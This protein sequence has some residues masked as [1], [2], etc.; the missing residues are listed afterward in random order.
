FLNQIRYQLNQRLFGPSLALRSVLLSNERNIT[1][2][3]Q[4]E[5]LRKT[6]KKIIEKD[7]NPYVEEWE[8]K[9][10]F[11]AHQVFKKFGEAGLL[12]ITRPTEYNGLG[13]DYSYSIAFFEELANINCGGIPTAITVQTDMA[14]PALTQFGSDYLKREFLAPTVAG[15]YV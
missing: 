15:D 5:E 4:H 13:L 12:G 3:A 11:P 8:E 9:D 6:V 14:I 7:V 2:T 10:I 1:F